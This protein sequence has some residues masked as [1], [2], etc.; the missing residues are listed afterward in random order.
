MSGD[1]HTELVNL[2]VAKISLVRHPANDRPLLVCKSAEGTMA[3][4]TKTIEVQGPLAGVIEFIANPEL[5]KDDV[6]KAALI[7]KGMKPEN[8]A[9]VTQAVKLLKGT[10]EKMSPEQWGQVCEACGQQPPVAKAAAETPA[11]PILKAIPLVN[12]Q[13][14]FSQIPEAVRPGIEALYKAHQVAKAEATAAAA[15]LQAE[16][17]RKSAEAKAAREVAITKSVEAHKSL[18]GDKAKLIGV[19][20]ALDGKPEFDDLSNVLKALDATLAKSALFAELGTA[21]GGEGSGPDPYAALQALA[22]ERVTKAAGTLTPAQAFA[23]V[24]KSKEGAALYEAY[25]NAHT[26]R[27]A[28]S[29][30][31]A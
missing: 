7:V 6:A 25:S 23:E 16:T 31:A 28:G 1:G 12:G 11:D 2:K 18:V 8:A 10:D 27:A 21:L 22:N 4:E 13:P 30:P 29:G 26:K 3:G 15:Q 20:K 5:G 19:L 14:D 17:V 9:K 24:C